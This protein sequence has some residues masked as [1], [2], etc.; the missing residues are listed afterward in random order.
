MKCRRAY[1][2]LSNTIGN[3][4]ENLFDYVFVVPMRLIVAEPHHAPTL[5]LWVPVNFHDPVVN[6]LARRLQS[7][8]RGKE[9][10]I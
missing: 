1:D 3:T 7:A 2:V 9:T 5:F 10:E 4:V 6:L 8:N